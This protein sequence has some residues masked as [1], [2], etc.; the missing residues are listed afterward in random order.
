MMNQTD[1]NKVYAGLEKY[2]YLSSERVMQITKN[3][4]DNI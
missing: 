1:N 2:I 3:N 4:N